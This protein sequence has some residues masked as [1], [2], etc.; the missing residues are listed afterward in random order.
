MR[1]VRLVALAALASVTSRPTVCFGAAAWQFVAS[2]SIDVLL[3]ALHDAESGAFVTLELGTDAMLAESA[4]AVAAKNGSA[5]Q[6]TTAGPWTYGTITRPSTLAEAQSCGPQQHTVDAQTVDA[7]TLDVTYSR[8]DSIAKCN[9]VWNFRAVTCSAAQLQRSSELLIASPDAWSALLIGWQDLRPITRA[10]LASIKTGDA[11][12]AIRHRL[13]TPKAV[14]RF[15]D[16][17]AVC[18]RTGDWDGSW[19]RLVFDRAQTLLTAEVVDQSEC[20]KQ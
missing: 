10:E 4:P 12:S 19:T 17:F 8:W 7:Q 5:I 3:G 1:A 9:R 15:R 6:R 16:G 14:G 13:G 2:E 20:L 18:Y 11:W